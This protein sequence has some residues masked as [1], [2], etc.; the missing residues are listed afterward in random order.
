MTL[1][2]KREYKYQVENTFFRLGVVAYSCNP[3]TW[4][5][6]VEDDLRSGVL[7]LSDSRWL[8]VRTKLGINLGALGELGAARLVKERRNGPGGKPSSQKS[9]CW[10]VVGSR[11][12]VGAEWQP[13]QQ[14]QTDILFS[15]S[16]IV[17]KFQNISFVH[18][19]V[20]ELQ[21]RRQKL[22]AVTD[23]LFCSKS[24]VRPS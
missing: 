15:I 8:G 7:V 6:D 5:P 21:I 17:F 14:S 1:N 12:G 23:Y 2:T 10:A 4:R 11:P 16:K 13:D 19:N 18:S 24:T 3:A 20:L 22:D 9:P